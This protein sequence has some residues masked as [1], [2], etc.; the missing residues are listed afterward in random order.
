M[1]RVGRSARGNEFG[2]TFAFH[3]LA[4]RRCRIVAGSKRPQ[5]L[6]RLRTEKSGKCQVTIPLLP[7][8]LNTLEAGPTA[9]LAYICGINGQA[10]D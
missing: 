8:L 3:R 4:P 1:K 9:E 6:A 5:W 2:L 10:A 7:L